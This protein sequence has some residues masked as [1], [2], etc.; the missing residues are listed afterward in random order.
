MP[1]VAAPPTKNRVQAS[2]AERLH[3]LAYNLW[4]TWNPEAHQV[5]RTLSYLIWRNSN[6]NAIA[7]LREVSIQELSARL[8][9]PDFSAQVQEVLDE[10]DSYMGNEA[11]WAHAHVPTLKNPVAYFS[12]EFGIHECL[13]VYSGG[14]GI[15]SGDHIKAASDLGIP[16]YGVGLFYRYGYFHQ[17]LGMDGWQQELYPPN[18]PEN[19]P[20]K[21]LESPEGERFLGSVEIGH[22]T[23]YFQAWAVDIGR[24]KLFLLDTNV[25]EN[26]QHY[27]N[28]TSNVY[29]GDIDTRIGQEILLG[30]GGARL[31][32]SMKI[33][34]SVYHM[35]EGHSAF[36][37]LELLSRELKSGKSRPEAEAAVKDK[38]LFTTHTPVPA[39][40]D[41][42][43][44]EL[45]QHAL[46][47]FWG[48]TGLTHQDMM[49]YG[50]VN[51]SDNNEQFTMTVLALKMSRAANGVSK[52]HGAVSREMW[53]SLYPGKSA[54]EVPIGHITNGIHTP[55]WAT[56][57]AHEFWNK[58]LGFDWTHRLVE[59]E[60]WKK[61]QSD[62]LASDEEL[63][64][65]RYLLRR[66]L[67]EFA[68][69][70]MRDMSFRL[71]GDGAP[72]WM[73]VLSPDVLT[74]GFGRRFATYKRATLL[75]RHLEQMIPLLND[76]RRP[77]QLI[78]AGKAHPRDNEGKK[79][80][81][82]VVEIARHPQLFG[83]V[84]FIENY[85]INVARE[86]IAGADVWLNTPRRPLE[87]SGT[88]GMKV[89]IHG[90]L[91]L[92]ILDGWWPEGYNGSNG[93]AIG[94]HD[95]D[96]DMDKQDEY[97]FNSL[98]QMLAERVI[99]EFYDRDEL[100]IPRK[101]L[102]RIRNSMETLIPL[103]NTTRMVAEYVTKYYAR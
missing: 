2:M 5:F 97:D 89:V 38:C 39:G 96:P 52:L 29:G 48:S 20:M 59:P 25:P 80:I 46:G 18:T 34:P 62:E 19:L 50:R 67:V 94:S 70:Q 22:S 82:R 54:D 74:I 13:P 69:R 64:A 24:V 58:R 100:G 92:S 84:V 93:W 8:R 43:G 83:K 14:L 27:Q 23:V 11:T 42:F 98:H 87:A 35:N 7:V 78:F 3:S 45:I 12:A 95:T 21:L 66:D 37:V 63:W 90:G 4:W 79:F 57:H 16:F 51:P 86:M 101:W 41:R 56:R 26:D 9:D 32:E 88:S 76:P 28:L 77:V 75:F 36:L 91:N 49:G 6:H 102:K 81:Q 73:Q 30:I 60:F 33:T 47:K 61:I 68:R 53:K 71:G 1:A 31:L 103:Y 99:P 17:R 15:L 85:D 65:L 44:S 10:F 55:G 72:A 40:H